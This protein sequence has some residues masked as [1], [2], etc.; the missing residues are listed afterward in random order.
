MDADRADE[1]RRDLD[2]LRHDFDSRGLGEV[3]KQNVSFTTAGVEVSVDITADNTWGVVPIGDFR[4]RVVNGDRRGVIRKGGTD[5]TA[6]TA[7]FVSSVDGLY[8]DL[9]ILF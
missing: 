4:Y 3:V 7:Y 1:T 5:W 2:T 9:A 8:A 6:T